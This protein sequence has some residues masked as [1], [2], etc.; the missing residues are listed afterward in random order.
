MLLQIGDRITD[1][2]PSSELGE[3]RTNREGRGY[4]GSNP[5]SVASFFLFHP[6]IF[7]APTISHNLNSFYSEL[8]GISCGNLFHQ[9]AKTLVVLQ[10]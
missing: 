5:G 3:S 9:K 8:D 10:L 1:P 7:S 6:L 2:Q 4:R